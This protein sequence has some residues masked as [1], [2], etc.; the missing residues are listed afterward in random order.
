M[1]ELHRTGR[2]ALPRLGRP[3][4]TAAPRKADRH[5]DAVLREGRQPRGPD[6]QEDRGPGL[7]VPGPRARAQPARQR[8]RRARR[9]ARRVLARCTRPRTPGLRVLADRRRVR[10]EADV[11]MVLLP[12]T[13]QK[14]IYDAEIAPHLTAGKCLLFAHG[15]NIRFDLITPP[16][17][18]R[19]GDGRAQGP[20]PP[21]APHLRRGR[22]RAVARSRSTRTPP[23]T[24]TRSRSPTPTASA[25]RA[26]ACSRRPS[27]RRPRPTSSASRRCSAAASPRWCARATRPSSRPATS[28]RRAYFECLH[29]LKLIVD[30]MY[31][32]G[33]TGMRFSRLGHRRVRRP[34]ARPA[35]H[36]RPGQ[37]RDEEGAHRDPGRLLRR[38][39]DPGE[40]D[41]P[42]AL[43]RA[44]RRRQEAPDRADRH[45]AARHDAL[46]LGAASRRS[47]T[48]RAATPTRWATSPSAP[49]GR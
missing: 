43:P 26:P 28:P 37:G 34:D 27:P 33:I 48:S 44:A 19:R 24:P 18:R 12:D 8:V 47:A 14:R 17:R 39:V 10:A 46:R 31:E 16:G 32:E 38:R 30:L 29:E 11:I 42:P 25:R 20:R 41:R 3:A 22:R 6:G 9:A 35:H 21:R 4:G 13:E 45:E 2:V 36:Q 15:F 5:D 40:R 49:A 23:A 7:R 1:V